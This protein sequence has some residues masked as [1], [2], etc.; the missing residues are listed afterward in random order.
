[1]HVVNA[2]PHMH[3][4]GT[5]FFGS[6]VGGP[7]DGERWLDSVGYDP[8]AGVLTQYTPA[9]DLSMSDEV[10]FGCSWRNTFDKPIGEGVGDDEM[11]ILFGYAYPY[12][13]SYSAQASP[14]GCLMVAPPLPGE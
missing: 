3:A 8:E 14:T 2:L 4:L 10:S 9:V 7:L 11:C 13:Q 1:M 5:A 12:E 6:F